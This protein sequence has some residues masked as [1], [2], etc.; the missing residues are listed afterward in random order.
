MV[1]A[2]T[3]AQKRPTLEISNGNGR[4]FELRARAIPRATPYVGSESRG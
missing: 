2:S 1:D 3:I 4:W